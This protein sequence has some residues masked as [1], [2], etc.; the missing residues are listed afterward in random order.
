[1]SAL[2]LR[3]AFSDFHGL[4]QLGNGTIP[5][6]EET[7]R[8]I[9]IAERRS[10]FERPD[11]FYKAYLDQRLGN[12]TDVA[13]LPWLALSQLAER[14]LER[15]GDRIVVR[16]ERFVEWHELLP[17]I[18]PLCVVVAFLVREGRGPRLGDDPREY[19]FE[20]LGETALLS[21]SDL[22]LDDLI[23][24]EGLHEL[25]MHLNGSTELDVL[26]N[27]AVGNPNGFYREIETEWGKNKREAAELY[28]QL[29]PGLTPYAIFKRLRAAR[30]VRRLIAEAL[31]AQWRTGR[32]AAAPLT[33]SA[34]NLLK[35]MKEDSADHAVAGLGGQPLA[36]DPS[37]L[38]HGSSK[39]RRIIKEAAWLYN[40][41]MHLS[42]QPAD[43]HAGRGLYFTLLVLSQLRRLSVQQ[44]DEFGFDQFQKYTLVGTR[45]GLERRYL[46]RFR[47]LNLRP[48]YDML[49]HLEG[50]FS[51]K[52]TVKEGR[53]LIGAIVEDFHGFAGC[54]RR[55][56]RTALP[57]VP[58]PCLTAAGC[59]GHPCEWTG[60]R[61]MELSLVG[62]FIKLAPDPAHDGARNA[63]D[64]K[65]RS[66]VERRARVLKRLVG[67][68]GTVRAMVRGVDAAANE[69]H[70]GP[71]AFAP[72][73][74]L[75]RRSGIG[76]S[77]YHAG[78][79]FRH[80]LSGMRAVE[81]ALTFLDL[82]SGDRIGHA[83]SIG[84][85]PALWTARTGERALL[86]RI[87]YLDDLVFAHRHLAAVSNFAGEVV[88]LE[89][90]IAVQSTALYGEEFSPALLSQEWRLR[91]LDPM[92]VS[93]VDR[94]AFAGRQPLQAETFAKQARHLSLTAIDEIAEA[95]FGYIAGMIEQDGAALDL[96]RRRHRLE[97]D[98]C[99]AWVEV[100]AELLPDSAYGVLQDAVLAEVNRRAVTLETLPTSNLRISYYRRLDEHH[101]FR[102]LG[103]RGPQ[104]TNRPTVVIGSDDPGI[105]A[106]NLKNEF[107]AI[108]AVLRTTF[109]MT[110]D[111]A[112]RVLADLN[113][114][115]RIRRF[116][117]GEPN[118]KRE[119]GKRSA[120]EAV[121]SCHSE[122]YATPPTGRRP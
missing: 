53:A 91:S 74:R 116:R 69:L 37:D 98:G 11:H 34:D 36:T 26:W 3:N 15:R 83:T 68:N 46:D 78:E 48:P 18:S 106:T 92:L 109:R 10:D 51:P 118:M 66:D 24:R 60:R 103:L 113:D 71:E 107:T 50:R 65:L 45:E 29:E 13:E 57:M 4:A 35:A 115:A 23:E 95:E 82:R 99:R 52:G 56:R 12:A 105:F 114:A 54:K 43:R 27:A 47:Q 49:A 62:H 39:H 25:H 111:E 44:A 7:R 77:T 81:E 33:I 32:A 122:I 117:P 89:T 28:D 112:S 17:Y 100:E 6:C 90:L 70:A 73:Y 42:R 1:M 80:L 58:P 88:K 41:L 63:R 84:I 76:R 16:Y 85:D 31:A 79:D 59:P 30:R 19:L 96:F 8:R 20:E 40:C 64:S 87:D 14:Y 22:H 94:S 75:A 101:L 9:F 110:A 104:L 61:L 72:A 21:T 55:D 102:W 108:A 93:L 121:A 5:S 67:E 119:A 38:L 97:S 120:P 86:H 2:I